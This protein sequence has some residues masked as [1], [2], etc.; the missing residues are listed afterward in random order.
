MS[1]SYTRILFE[2]NYFTGGIIN[3]PVSVCWDFTQ[4]SQFQ[5]D[6]TLLYHNRWHRR[7]K[8]NS[9]PQHWSATFASLL[10]GWLITTVSIGSRVAV[11][12]SP[13]SCPPFNQ[14]LY[15]PVHLLLCSWNYYSVMQYQMGF[16]AMEGVA[17]LWGLPAHLF[18]PKWGLA[19]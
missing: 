13:A 7:G 17:L 3:L 9:H 14:R 5:I 8:L 6:W 16:Q 18:V 15:S 10:S 11:S 12:S 4:N 2:S 19:R 1:V